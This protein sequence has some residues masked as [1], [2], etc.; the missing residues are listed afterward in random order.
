[1]GLRFPSL[2]APKWEGEYAG[3][4]IKQLMED[5]GLKLF[6]DRLRQDEEVEAKL[7]RLGLA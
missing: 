7:R 2:E 4:T 6:Q 3:W 1:M 5:Y